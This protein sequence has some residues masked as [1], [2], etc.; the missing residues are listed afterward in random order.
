M[1]NIFTRYLLIKTEIPLFYD[2][3]DKKEENHTVFK[4]RINYERAILLYYIR[5]NQMT[6]ADLWLTFA[7][8]RKG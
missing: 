1:D 8:C 5:T 4:R 3:V 6:L 7:Q 2:L